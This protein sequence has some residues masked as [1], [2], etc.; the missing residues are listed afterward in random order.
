MT[1]A[2]ERKQREYISKEEEPSFTISTKALMNTLVIDAH[3]GR[4]IGTCYIVGACLNADM[5]EFTTMKLE[6]EVVNMMV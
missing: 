4:D 6:G 5:D 3:E 2:D 1:C